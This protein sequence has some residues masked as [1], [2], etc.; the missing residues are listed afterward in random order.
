MKSMNT[1]LGLCRFGFR[2]LE[3]RTA[4]SLPSESLTTNHSTLIAIRTIHLPLLSK[5]RNLSTN[6]SPT[7]HLTNSPSTDPNQSMRAPLSKA[8]IIFHCNIQIAMP[9]NLHPLLNESGTEMLSGTTPRSANLSN[10][11]L[12]EIS[13][14]SSINTFQ[15]PIP[16]TKYLIGIPSRSA[17]VVCPT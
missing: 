11:I 7:S 9:P 5:Y 1:V 15:R 2:P 16:Y 3:I 10:Q 14:N 13:F 4:N 6:V 8:I 17:T 12:P